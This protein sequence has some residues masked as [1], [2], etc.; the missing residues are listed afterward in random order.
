MLKDENNNPLPKVMVGI[1]KK[2]K[3]LTLTKDE[4]TLKLDIVDEE[5]DLIELDVWISEVLY[6]VSK[7]APPKS[8]FLL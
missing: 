2:L 7:E 4:N 5:I 6:N 8:K 1:T 3:K